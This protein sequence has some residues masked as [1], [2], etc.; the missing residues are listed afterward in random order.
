VT[1]SKLIGEQ[2]ICGTRRKAT[3][4][5]ALALLPLVWAIPLA[6][7]AQKA[8]KA[9]HIGI[10]S[11]GEL[12]NRSPHDA[13]LVEGLRDEGYVEGKNLFVERRYNSN[14]LTEN[15][16]ELAGM[17]LDAILTTCTP[18][19]RI[20]KQATAST[21]IVMVAVSDPVQQGLVASLARPGGN[22]TGTSSQ[23]EDLL[24][25]RLELVSLTIPKSTTI[26]VLAI[27]DNPAHALGWQRL[28]T[29]AR[30]MN[31]KLLRVDLAEPY[32]VPA[33]VKAAVSANAGALFVLPDDPIM[34]NL[35]PQIVA[36]AAQNRLP[37]F[38]WVREYVESGGLMSYG[39]SLR[40]SYR[41]GAEYVD[42][43]KKGANPGELPVQQPTKF[44]LVINLKTAQ[45]LGLTIPES[46]ILRADEVIQ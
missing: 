21:P 2:A 4:V 22:V 18:S 37:D 26:A 10:L 46:L 16:A 7:R 45:A 33:A 34:F 12:E 23:A 19:T 13:A 3:R 43:I 31:L 29:A 17:K 36:L 35:R 27:A 24:A 11:S 28:Q 9:L 42:K 20:M 32:D 1:T 44:E 25:K 14:R 8:D 30:K 38:Y 40:A 5:V 41:A 15:A 39:E 6:P